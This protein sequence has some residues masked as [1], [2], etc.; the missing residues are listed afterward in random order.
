MRIRSVR[1]DVRRVDD[2]LLPFF[3]VPVSILHLP[4]YETVVT[5]M[6]VSLR[7]QHHTV[8][9]TCLHIKIKGTSHPC[10]LLQ[11]SIFDVE[12]IAALRIPVLIPKNVGGTVRRDC[13]RASVFDQTRLGVDLL[14][15]PPMVLK[16]RIFEHCGREANMWIPIS[17]KADSCEN[18]FVAGRR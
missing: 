9:L 2:R 1:T 5:D 15:I 18:L 17:I 10:S 12:V 7:I 13:Q 3:T 8:P 11:D 4:L 14:N 16:G 6:R